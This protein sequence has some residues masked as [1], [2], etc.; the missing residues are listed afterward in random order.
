MRNLLA[1]AVLPL[2]IASVLAPAESPAA[3]PTGLQRRQLGVVAGTLRKAGL[4][5]QNG[6]TSEAVDAL[7]LALDQLNKTFG[8]KPDPDVV[9]FAGPV[10]QQLTQVHGLLELEGIKLDPLPSFTGEGSGGTTPAGTG[11]PG[12][13][14]FSKEIAPFLVTRCGRC[15][16]TQ[17]RGKVSMASYEA[18]MKGHPDDGPIILPNNSKGSRMIEVIESGDMPRG[19]GKVP[20]E[21]FA[22]LAKWID[23][24]AKS[25][26]PNPATPLTQFAAAKASNTPMLPVVMATGKESVKFALDV[27]PVLVSQCNDCHG[28][29]RPRARF[30]IATFSS[31]LRGGESGA[32]IAPGKPAESLLVRKL[33]G[34]AGDRMPLQRPPLADEVIAKIETWIAEGAKFDGEDAGLPLSRVAAVARART[35]TAEQLSD[36]RQQLAERNWRLAIPDQQA[37]RATT[38]NFLVFGTLGEGA[39]AEAAELAEAQV[40]KVATALKLP[41]DKQLIKG[42]VSLF[43][44]ANRFDYSEF[45]TMVEKRQLPKPWRGHWRFDIL[46][47]YVVVLRQSNEAYSME[48][49]AAQQLAAIYVASLGEG[50]APRWFAEGLGRA[51]AA[52]IGADDP[53]VKAWDERVTEI[54]AQLSQPDDF[55]TGKLPPEESD[56]LSYSFVKFLMTD[57]A[58]LNKLLKSLDEGVAFDQALVLAYGRPAPLLA[59]LWLQRGVKRR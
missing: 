1:W 46:D 22:L 36:E 53:R 12:A 51:V 2:V 50:A 57:S 52:K 49:L 4:L 40:A 41:A 18:L 17:T 48:V 44:F 13:V 59:P 7:K 29:R 26:L 28:G 27:A 3:A 32:A 9:K 42:R 23:Q 14:S 38:N 6:K 5:H 35:L 58:R 56:I 33:K 54:V 24:G 19:G 45:G 37:A 16:V 25:D 34:Q 43:V 10:L 20:A 11:A 31:L 21:E 15:H 30:S 39:L 55:L 8:E 47:P